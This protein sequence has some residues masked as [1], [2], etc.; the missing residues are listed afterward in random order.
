MMNSSTQPAHSP[1]DTQQPSRKHQVTSVWVGR[2]EFDDRQCEQK[3]RYRS[4]KSDGLHRGAKL[5]GV[6]FWWHID[7]HWSSSEFQGAVGNGLE[8]LLLAAFVDGSEDVQ[9]L[10]SN[11]GISGELDTSELR[12]QRLC[13]SM[14]GEIQ[15]AIL[16]DSIGVVVD[17]NMGVP[18]GRSDANGRDSGSAV[19][20]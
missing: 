15:K 19:R 12:G 16:E 3:I 1:S 11:W 20:D 9:E 17:A 2:G 8:A 6:R 18:L 7:L 10:P 13:R 5:L 4:H 14:H